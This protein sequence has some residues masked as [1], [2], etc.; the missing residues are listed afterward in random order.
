MNG[1]AYRGTAQRVADW[2]L[3]VQDD[4]GG[5]SNFQN[6]DG[7]TRALQSGNVNFY[8]S[9]ALWLFNEVYLNGR[10][11]LFSVPAA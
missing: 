10:I 4:K 7:S 5:F 6:P 3:T 1:E 8:A 11:R 2:T 9:M